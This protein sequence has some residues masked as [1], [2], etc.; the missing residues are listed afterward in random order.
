MGVTREGPLPGEV[1]LWGWCV[2]PGL[3]WQPGSPS[4]PARLSLQEGPTSSAGLQ[5]APHLCLP[6]R[7]GSCRGWWGQDGQGSGDDS[8][9]EPG[10]CSTID[11]APPALLWAREGLWSTCYVPP[12]MAGVRGTAC[13]RLPIAAEPGPPARLPAPTP[14]PPLRQKGALGAGG[15]L[16]QPPGLTN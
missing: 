9:G 8:A 10:W 5:Q 6:P 13:R 14:P 1:G 3:P 2:N 12:W 11:R 15:S 16:A 7:E 4:V